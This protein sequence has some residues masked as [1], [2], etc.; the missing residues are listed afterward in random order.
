ML[1]QFTGVTLVRP[2][3]W[4]ARTHVSADQHSH[5]GREI[6]IGMFKT[7]A[8]AAFAVNTATELL[9]DA[10]ARV[11]GQVPNRVT[12]SEREAELVTDKVM[13]VLVAAL[14]TRVLQPGGLSL[15]LVRTNSTHAV[16]T[17][18]S[19]LVPLS[20]AC[21]AFASPVHV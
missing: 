18:S 21:S 14:G 15:L 10:G 19:A 6:L 12:V 11:P 8:Q 7:C 16:G 1:A 13:S 20:C 17:C 5:G 2:G 4:E 3:Q 9:V